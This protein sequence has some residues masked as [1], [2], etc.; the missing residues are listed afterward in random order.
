M[1]VHGNTEEGV[2]ELTSHT[3]MIQME[4]EVLRSG[5]FVCELSWLFAAS[6]PLKAIA[7]IPLV[8]IATHIQCNPTAMSK[9][10]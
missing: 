9:L 5:V 1:E 8:L 3:D 2:L 10:L 7:H 4:S 6:Y